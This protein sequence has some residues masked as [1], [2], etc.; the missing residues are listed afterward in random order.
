MLTQCPGKVEFRSCGLNGEESVGEPGEEGGVADEVGVHVV[1]YRQGPSHGEE[2]QH[3]A[4][5]DQQFSTDSMLQGGE[6][7]AEH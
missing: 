6:R 4:A 5:A 7:T 1:R 2:E 3:T